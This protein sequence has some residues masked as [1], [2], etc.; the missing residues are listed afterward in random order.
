[1]DQKNK[2]AIKI[3]D[4]IAE[5][6]ARR[7]DCIES[8]DDMIFPDT[9]LSHLSVG[10]IIIDLGC[11]TGFTSKYFQ[12]NGMNPEGVD[13][14]K[15]MINIADRNYSDIKFSVG[16]MR[17]FSPEKTVDAVWAGYSMFNFEQEFFENTLEKIKTYLK[18][19]GIFG[20]VMQEGTGEIEHVNP[21]MPEEKIYIH[22]YDEEQ[23]K[24]ILLKHGFEIIKQ[25]IKLAENFEFPYN[26]ILLISK[27]K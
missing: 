11:G 22:L 27:L 26:K 17:T 15:S 23:L 6:Y 21:F 10:S 12:K 3:Y 19:D 9:F 18:R 24:E 20:I 16:D 1:M 8:A 7:F 25:K 4:I 2:K 5:D 13:L 14:S